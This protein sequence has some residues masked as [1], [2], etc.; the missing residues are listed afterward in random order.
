VSVTLGRPQHGWNVLWVLSVLREGIPITIVIVR[1]NQTTRPLNNVM[2]PISL[3]MRQMV[4]VYANSLIL[5]Y[6]AWIQM[7]HVQH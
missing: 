5:K 7:R 1:M 2:V 4:I 6:L 3:A